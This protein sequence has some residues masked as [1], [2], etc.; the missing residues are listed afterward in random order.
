[1]LWET[2]H[3]RDPSHDWLTGWKAACFYQS[4]RR[5]VYSLFIISWVLSRVCMALKNRADTTT[6]TG[7]GKIIDWNLQKPPQTQFP[8]T[9]MAI[10]LRW[11]RLH[12]QNRLSSDGYLSPNCLKCEEFPSLSSQEILTFLFFVS[13]VPI[14]SLNLKSSKNTSKNIY[15]GRKLDYCPYSVQR[16]QPI[17]KMRKFSFSTPTLG[18]WYFSR[19]FV[20]LFGWFCFCFFPAL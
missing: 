11:H 14:I 17:R 9:V 5:Q 19:G 1:M 4:D 13:D 15:K 12:G 8:G 7:K 6:P 2:G 16:K 20:C 10:S 18:T 3:S